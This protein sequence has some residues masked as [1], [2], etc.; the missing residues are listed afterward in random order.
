MNPPFKV[1]QLPPQ[2]PYENLKS[3]E[4]TGN[5]YN[6]II[7][8]GGTAGCSLARVLSQRG[9][10]KILIIE[11]GNINPDATTTIASNYPYTWQSATNGITTVSDYNL[12]LESQVNFVYGTSIG[13]SSN[14]NFLVAVQPS[15]LY[16]NELAGTYVPFTTPQMQT[17]MNDLKTY[18]PV[19][20][21]STGTG[22]INI[23][24]IQGTTTFVNR[25]TLASAME[26]GLGVGSLSNY[27][28]RTDY[29]VDPYIQNFQLDDERSSAKSLI[30]GLPNITI[31]PNLTVSK[32]VVEGNT[33]TGVVVIEDGIS[34]II[35]GSNVILTAGTIETARIMIESGFT[36]QVEFKTHIGSSIVVETPDMRDGWN[37]NGPIGFSETSGTIMQVLSVPRAYLD[38]SVV[39]TVSY[40]PTKVFSL[41]G[42]VLNPDNPSFIRLSNNG[43]LDI[44]TN[45]YLSGDADKLLTMMRQLKAI[46]DQLAGIIL[47]YPNVDFNDDQA[48]I[49]AV[50]TNPSITFHMNG[51][52]PLGT[53]LDSS[54]R[55]NGYSGLR[56]A[57]LSCAPVQPDGNTTYYAMLF[58]TLCGHSF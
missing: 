28:E 40:D 22:P 7:V 20:G 46:V 56:I 35:S 21:G 25:N 51:T 41:L 37:G 24:Q 48:L 12:L 30:T 50:R 52:F 38:K 3:G 17:W 18:Y 4:T 33:I 5:V 8:G 39:N 1:L 15:E 34:R 14:I 9:F 32:L 55:Y 16:L 47:V 26:T 43:T 2:I 42:W 44:T 29:G 45:M 49:D 11:R 58:G 27:N 19:T 53:A 54:F 31:L 6:Y 36:S 13:G 23:T 10:K 57:D